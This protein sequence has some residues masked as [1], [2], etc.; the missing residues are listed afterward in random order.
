[1]H[2]QASTLQPVRLSLKLTHLILH[3]LAITAALPLLAQ[4]RPEM[5]TQ[6]GGGMEGFMGQHAP[7]FGPQGRWVAAIGGKGALLVFDRASGRLAR[8]VD[9]GISI[10]SLSAHPAQDEIILTGDDKENSPVVA[11]YNVI[12][13][14]PVWKASALGNCFQA[15]FSSSGAEA[16][17]FCSTPP[18]SKSPSTGKT[19]RW[20]AADGAV[21]LPSSYHSQG[22]SINTVSEN[23]E[24][25]SSINPNAVNREAKLMKS[26]R[27]PKRRS[28][29]GGDNSKEEQ[30]ALADAEDEIKQAA[31]SMDNMTSTFLDAS[32]GKALG[33]ASGMV[34]AISA[35]SRTAVVADGTGLVLIDIVTGK[36]ILLLG[37]YFQQ[38]PAT[39]FL[40]AAVSPDGSRFL[41]A[42]AVHVT[43]ID[44]A[45][46]HTERDISSDIPFAMKWAISPDNNELA[47]AQGN[48]VMVFNLAGQTHQILGDPSTVMMPGSIMA[49]SMAQDMSSSTATQR[50]QERRRQEDQYAKAEGMAHG[51][52]RKEMQKR[53]GELARKDAAD[54]P[55]ANQEAQTKQDT[56]NSMVQYMGTMGAVSG[57]PPAERF[58][59]HARLLAVRTADG[60]WGVWDTATGN[61]LPYRKPLGDLSRYEHAGSSPEEFLDDSDLRAI[62]EN[63]GI[64][65]R[66]SAPAKNLI[67]DPAA[68]VACSSPGGDHWVEINRNGKK[69]SGALLKSGDGTTVDLL[70]K[71]VDLSSFNPHGLFQSMFMEASKSLPDAPR[72]KANGTTAN[73]AALCTLSPAGDRLIVEVERPEAKPGRKAKTDALHMGMY[74][75]AYYA[76][77]F[78]DSLVLYNVADGRRLCELE[79]PLKP[80]PFDLSA[81]ELVFSSDSKRIAAGGRRQML[82]KGDERRA[83]H[84]WDGETC[85]QIRSIESADSAT[86]LGFS[87]DDALLFTGVTVPAEYGREAAYGVHVWNAS[88]GEHLFDL[89]DAVAATS[90]VVL[91]PHGKTLLAPDRS[92]AL[93]IWSAA[94]G[95]RLGMLRALPQGEW[96]V[97]AQSGLFDGSPRGW[98]QIA[99]RDPD[100]LKTEPA[101]VFFTDFYRPGLFAELLDGHP[102]ALPRNFAQVDR[103]QPTV[104]L[105]ASS[106]GTAQRTIHLQIEATE[107][108]SGASGGGGVRDVRLFRNGILIKAWRGTLPL[109][110]GKTILQAVEPVVA[111]A[112]HFTAYAF[113]H[114]NV[115]SVDAETLVQGT[116]P[117]RPGTV[118]LL[119]VGVN[120]YSNDEFN[121]RYAAPDATRMAEAL[122]KSQGKAGRFHEIVRV[123]LLDRNA[124]KANILLALNRLAGQS[125]GK[126]PPDVPPILAQLRAVQPE[127][128]VMIYFAGHGIAWQD[129]FYLVPHDL[130]YTG[131][132]SDLAGGIDAVLRHSISDVELETSLEPLDASH[133]LLVI[134]ACNS[135]KALDAEEQRRGPMNTRGLAQ[136]AYEKGI[137]VLTASQSYQA[138][139]ESSRLGHG[140]LTYALAEEGLTLA[141]T[142]PVDGKITAPEW[143]EYASSRVPQLQ[144]TAMGEGNTSG[145]Q[146]TFESDAP[147]PAGPRTSRLQTPRFYY[148]RGALSN[149]NIIAIL[150]EQH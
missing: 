60:G 6:G 57:F 71:G 98:S 105:S 26:L 123:D 128:S 115:K 80:A 83:L 65:P 93:G 104:V 79:N 137:D 34:L 63:L 101:E 36:P 1:M 56:M 132:R 7:V 32:S 96:L 118:F 87:D 122:E 30:Q 130:G 66:A 42:G 33:S 58:L 29:F 114:D 38:D 21:L 2:P 24:I 106:P 68:D 140:Y 143:F 37:K 35:R 149:E 131:S 110:Q 90:L 76:H 127:D 75:G 62:E 133:I 61:P 3:L 46:G 146:L 88:N 145:R 4:Q 135:G 84:I 41:L 85:R 86:P 109:Q 10:I 117:P 27:R 125:Q 11:V 54:Q 16:L 47:A 124:T 19:L 92:N 134:D 148:R 108:S 15:R 8:S 119:A 64:R 50:L 100:G 99:W 89:P 77:S 67:P 22:W 31:T 69:L 12:T 112:N 150:P 129:H 39:G 82:G 72:R 20:S 116:A 81:G 138:A 102:P 107:A 111:G 53:M 141:D 120:Q 70:A 74:G 144:I 25:S 136:L 126:L 44:S 147:T 52:I 9:T 142:T 18:Y 95:S 139:L 78:S 113:N 17:A 48:A 5:V 49:K 43:V 97:T 59:D 94:D 45:T 55:R 51:S 91:G 73:Q 121:L 13:G 14:K 40:S 23:G 103:R 28:I